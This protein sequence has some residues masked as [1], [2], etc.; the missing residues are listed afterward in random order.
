[1]NCCCSN[2]VCRRD[3]CQAGKTSFLMPDPIVGISSHA[4]A[5]KD[6]RITALT[7]ALRAARDSLTEVRLEVSYLYKRD[8]SA[9]TMAMVCA[10]LAQIDAILAAQ[11]GK[12]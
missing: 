3:G 10:S 8:L 6:A 12:P 9:R 4:L 5:A 2:P 1:M 7:D 11:K